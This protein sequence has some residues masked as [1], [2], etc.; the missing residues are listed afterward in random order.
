MTLRPLWLVRAAQWLVAAFAALVFA[1]VRLVPARAASDLGGL[2][3]RTIGPLIPRSA[4]ARRQ[5]EAAFPDKSPAEIKALVRGVWDNLGRTALEYPHLDQIWDYK[6][7]RPAGQGRIDIVGEDVFWAL[8]RSTRPAIIFT[9][10]L[11]N[12]ELLAI[13]AAHHGL[14]VA[15]F[16]RRPNNPYINRLITR[17]RGATMG[18]LIPTDMMGAITATQL[19]EQGKHIGLLADQHFSRGPRI[20]FFG[21]PAH[22]APTL[23]KLALRYDCALHGAWV[24][25][26]PEGRFRLSI[27][28]ALPL[29][30]AGTREERIDA[31]LATVNGLVEGWVR[32]RPEQWL[33]LHRRWR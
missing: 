25:R 30:S 6:A 20:P 16:F 17:I 14:P 32:A 11:A 23:A 2:F 15:V 19:L 9:A 10:H 31:L 4:V 13:A 18:A 8:K 12:W 27:T 24:E 22:T 26:L 7:G 21:R 28:E 5:L 33:W 3:A 29:P 1:L